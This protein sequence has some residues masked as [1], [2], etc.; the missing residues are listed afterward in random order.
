MEKNIGYGLVSLA[1]L[2][3]VAVAVIM[4]TRPVGELVL[5]ATGLLILQLTVAGLWLIKKRP[6]P[7]RRRPPGSRRSNN[8][9]IRRKKVQG[10]WKRF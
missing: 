4:A 9:Q 3:I 8:G 6:A 2:L 7:K 5:L 10:R 1:A